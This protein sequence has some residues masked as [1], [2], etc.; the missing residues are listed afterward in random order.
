[1]TLLRADGINVAA[2]DGKNIDY[3]EYFWCGECEIKQRHIL[4]NKCPVC[5]RVMRSVPTRRREGVFR[6]GGRET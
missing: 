6:L 3:G 5:G 2:C 1:M 4:G